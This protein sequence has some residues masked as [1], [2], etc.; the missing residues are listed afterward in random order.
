M[1]IG[2]NRDTWPF[3]NQCEIITLDFDKLIFF[4]FLNSPF[5][6]GEGISARVAIANTEKCFGWADLPCLT[7]RRCHS[8]Q[9]VVF[10]AV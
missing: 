4:C 8:T 10:Q 2:S 5:A 6:K 3:N 9:T 7:N 1:T